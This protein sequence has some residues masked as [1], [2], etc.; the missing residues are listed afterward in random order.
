MA[1]KRMN[2]IHEDRVVA[3]NRFLSRED[4]NTGTLHTEKKEV[5]FEVV[6]REAIP[7]PGA[8]IMIRLVCQDV[9]SGELFFLDSI[10]VHTFKVTWD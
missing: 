2:P 7:M 8:Q 9:D 4:G 5:E 10:K 1:E 6:R 3:F